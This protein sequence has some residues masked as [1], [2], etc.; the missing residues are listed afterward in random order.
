MSTR[1]T[2]LSQGLFVAG[3][4]SPAMTAAQQER[5]STSTSDAVKSMSPPKKPIIV[6]RYTGDRTIAES[7]RMLEEGADTL[8]AAHHVC[9]GRENDPK[10]HSVGLG[11]LPNEEGIVELDASCM[12]GPTRAAGAV[13]AIRNIKNVCLVARKVMERTSHVM[14]AG[15]GAER[16]AVTEGF[17]REDL[18]TDDARKIWLLWKESRSS[19]GWWGPGLS[20]PQWTPPEDDK[21][22]FSKGPHRL[23][24]AANSGDADVI[25]KQSLVL[26]QRAADCG[27]ATDQRWEAVKQ[28]LW[29]TMGTIN[30]SALNTKGE[31]STATTTSG[32]AWKIP[33][34]LGDSPIIGAGCY[35]DQDVGSAGATGSGE[36]NIKVAGAHTIVDL[37]RTGMSPHDAGLEA[38][39]RIARNYNG[40]MR[41]LRYVDMIYYILR[42][43]GAYAGCSMWST[44]PGGDVVK[45]VVHDGVER[46]ENCAYL[47]KGTSMDWPPRPK[48]R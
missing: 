34:R 47:F 26:W 20:S 32:A 21:I 45:F 43:D 13:G 28:I 37:M 23:P 19:H 10:D 3:G 44:H 39:R 9:I 29:P 1:R 24:R 27:V 35:A 18:L 4:L 30:V 42:K 7:Y 12:H 36:E 22:A 38:L 16:F 8:E 25:Q 5:T 11:G 33:G 40:D 41:K 17:P 31:L 14:L 46:T 48:A 6:T 15:E 2:F